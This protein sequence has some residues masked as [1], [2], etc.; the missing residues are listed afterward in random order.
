MT[1]I[2]G[3]ESQVRVPEKKSERK[4]LAAERFAFDE[5]IAKGKEGDGEEG[6]R[7]SKNAEQPEKK[8]PD[9]SEKFEYRKIEEAVR[10]RAL[11][12]A[13]SN[14]KVCGGNTRS[15]DMDERPRH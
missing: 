14:Q 4:E 9:C 12:C 10:E 15:A 11:C 8:G 3:E 13:S 1:S 7:K 6:G 5:G 2:H